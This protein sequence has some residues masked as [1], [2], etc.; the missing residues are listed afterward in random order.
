MTSTLDVL[1]QGRLLA[2]SFDDLL[3][4]HG[5][6]SPGGV[7]QGFKVLERGLPLLDPDGP[8]ERRE[9]HIRTAFGGPGARDALELVTRAVTGERF[10]VD[11]GLAR[12][13]LGF[14]SERF[15]FELT[16]RDRTATLVVREGIVLDEFIRLARTEGKT[17]EQKARFA[18]LKLEL[19]HRIMPMP[20]DEVYDVD[21]DA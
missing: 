10:V 9:I 1:D 18:E 13:E 8:P 21:E 14:A 7:A 2:F 15:V 4:Y 3:K 19:V 12:P 17:E 6:G 16:Y 11:Q 5:P 20:A